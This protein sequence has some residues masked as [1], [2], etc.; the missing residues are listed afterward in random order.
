MLEDV[1]DIMENPRTHH[2]V[3]QWFAH[4]QVYRETMND[5]PLTDHEKWVKILSHP[6]TFY[7]PKK[8]RLP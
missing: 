6:S 4:P 8:V 2:Y 1:K 5:T 3:P 7:E